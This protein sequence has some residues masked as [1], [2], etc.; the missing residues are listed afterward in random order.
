VRMHRAAPIR[1]A[2]TVQKKDS[3]ALF[4]RALVLEMALSADFAV[5]EAD[6][7]HS[8]AARL[9]LTSSLTLFIISVLTQALKTWYNRSDCMV[10]HRMVGYRMVGY[11]RWKD[12]S[13][14]RIAGYRMAGHLG[15]YGR[16][17]QVGYRIC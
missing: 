15:L 14:S 3:T 16:I 8:P 7:E 9:C 6:A 10:G 17:S 1:V 5:L 11:K 4:S 2:P 12:I 13:D